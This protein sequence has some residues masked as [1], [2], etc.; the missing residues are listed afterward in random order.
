MV[1][2]IILP[3]YYSDYFC[4]V[5]QDFNNENIIGQPLIVNSGFFT[6]YRHRKIKEGLTVIEYKITSELKTGMLEKRYR[7]PANY[8]DLVKELDTTSDKSLLKKKLKASGME[9]AAEFVEKSSLQSNSM[10]IF[11]KNHPELKKLEKNALTE[12]MVTLLKN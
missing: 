10:M 8:V 2:E 6:G 11:I 1:S 3:S 9:N 12:L 4:S 7:L 5:L